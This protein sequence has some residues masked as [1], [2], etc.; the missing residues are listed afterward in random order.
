VARKDR[1]E[2]WVMKS[3]VSRALSLSL[4]LYALRRPFKK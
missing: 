4:S 3:I 1:D 2:M